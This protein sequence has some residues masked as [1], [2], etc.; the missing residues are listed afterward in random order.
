LRGFEYNTGDEGE[1][2]CLSMVTTTTCGI[3]D[4]N[5]SQ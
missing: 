4:R 2:Q 3:I 1:G 5:E